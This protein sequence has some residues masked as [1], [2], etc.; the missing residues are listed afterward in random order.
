MVI[1]LEEPEDSIVVMENPRDK[2]DSSTTEIVVG[3]I[4][5]FFSPLR[6]EI[7]PFTRFTKID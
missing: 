6:L 2:D 1:Y 5:Y 4:L 3:K 7:I